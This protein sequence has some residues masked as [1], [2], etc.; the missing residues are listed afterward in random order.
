M[1]DPLVTLSPRLSILRLVSGVIQSESDSRIKLGRSES[2]EWA[3]L[4]SFREAFMKK[5]STLKWLLLFTAITIIQYLAVRLGLLMGIAHGNVSPVWPATGF[6]IGVLFRFGISFWPGIFL[7]SFLSL[8][9][10]DV[11][12]LVT[13]GESVAALLEA[14]IAIFLVRR[15]I[16][17]PDPFTITRNV[18]LFCLLAGVTATAI[19]AT[20]GVGSLFYGGIIPLGSIGYH[21]GTW[22]LGDAMGAVIVAPALI[23]W[24]SGPW[25]WKRSGWFGEVLV[26]TTLFFSGVV[27]FWGPFVSSTGVTDYPM[28]FFT[29]AMVVAATFSSGRKGATAAC[30]ICSALAI[31]G[32]AQGWGPFFR[33]S[34]NESL[35]LLQS[36]LIVISVTAIILA[37]VL[38]ERDDAVQK[39]RESRDN[40]DALIQERTQELLIANAQLKLQINERRQTEKAL[41]ES[42]ER[43]R[44]FFVTS[45]ECIFITS[46]KGSVI[47]IN[48]SGL[49]LFG[50]APEDRSLVYKTNVSQLYANPE[51]RASH[52]ELISKLGY[53]KDYPMDLLKRD[54]SVLKCLITTV[55]RRDAAGNVVGFQGTIRDITEQKRTEETLKTTLHR[56]HAIL[57]SLYAGVL[58]VS[59]QG[60]VEF[61]NQAFC[62]L[63]DLQLS[64]EEL[65]GLSSSIMIGKIIRVYS[66]PAAA[67]KRIRQVVANN[68]PVKGEEIIISKNRTYMVDYVP[69]EVAGK[70]AGR[71]WHHNDITHLKK[72]EEE[73]EKL[74]NQLFMSQKMEA[75][76]TLVSGIAHD[77]NNLLTIINGYAE[78]IMLD[79]G[80]NDT[81]Y[82]DLQKIV[83][84]GLKGADLVKRLLTF[85]RNSE[86]TKKPVDVNDIV[87]EITNLLRSIFPKLI[88]IQA[89]TDNNLMPIK[90]DE[91]QI[92]QVLM[93]LCINS[94]DA[95][96]EGGK[97]KIKTK[98]VNV[99]EEYCNLHIEANPGYHVLVEVSDTGYGISEEII[100][101]IFDPF[102]TTKLRDYNKGTGLGLSVAK[103]IIEQHEGWITCE[104]KS[105]V[106]TTFEMYFPALSNQD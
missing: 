74:K 26:F 100:G 95:M 106:G 69:L 41:K 61:V 85:C 82:Q 90:A 44:N 27:A 42:E 23:I 51:E 4:E 59:E 94:K 80:R 13:T 34:V 28:A 52:A 73:R 68:I 25:V 99:S 96:P 72:T 10:T 81:S 6:A 53:S 24:T 29:L 60:E 75:L 83:E 37:T 14:L 63:F 15:F 76:G 104:S 7:G 92:Q 39:L 38:K 66:D 77:F 87:Q 8:F 65:R 36:Y 5:N 48:D 18:V 46:H 16:S 70:G 33:G 102:F 86:L 9:Q 103:G 31:S 50:Y 20:I 1:I 89:Q 67:E 88:E 45:R 40:L 43:Y 54:G 64:P 101:R 35:L 78:M 22:W 49:E 71:L 91:L 98:N 30:L 17:E 105:G 58:I 19:S 32:T 79:K 93:N 97:L 57:S 21:W 55:T 11:G 47:D 12:L 62:D 56:F 2:S 3:G 84:T